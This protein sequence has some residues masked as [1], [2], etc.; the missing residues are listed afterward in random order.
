MCG[1][2]GSKHGGLTDKIYCYSIFEKK[3]SKSWYCCA[4]YA[5]HK[6]LRPVEEKM[7]F[8]YMFDT[9]MGLPACAGENLDFGVGLR[10]KCSMS[11]WFWHLD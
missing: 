1:T 6:R 4:L 5:Y 3:F 10:L 7:E 11:K 2:R 8:G 9:V